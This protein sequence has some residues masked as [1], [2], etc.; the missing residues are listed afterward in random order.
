[1]LEF[2]ARAPESLPLSADAHLT[3]VPIDAEVVSLS[4]ILLDD[5]YYAFLSA[6]TRELGGVRVVTEQGLIPLKARAWLDLAERR[7]ADP[8]SVD[9]KQLAKHRGDV[10]RLSQL[11][12]ENERIAAAPSIRDD[13]ARFANEVSAQI[14]DSYLQS[15]GIDESAG[16]LLERIRA[17][18]GADA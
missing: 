14:D 15:L 13:V 16:A 2:F 10:M 5:D 3:S 6:N 8:G 11:L 18:Y 17:V 7:A 4:A 9:A 12:I 1:M